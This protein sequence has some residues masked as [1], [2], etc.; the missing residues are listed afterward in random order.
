MVLLDWGIFYFEVLP[1]VIPGERV[2]PGDQEQCGGGH[3]RAGK[4]ED[5]A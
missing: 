4:E 2:P 3:H 1:S 5:G